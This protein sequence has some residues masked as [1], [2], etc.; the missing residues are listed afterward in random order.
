[1]TALPSITVIVPAHNDVGC[2]AETVRSCW[3][4]TYAPARVIVVAD[5]CTD[6]TAVVAERAGA[7]VILGSGG[8]KAGAQNLALP[9]VDTEVVVALDSNVTMAP[10]S[11]EAFAA[12]IADGYA[13]VCSV[14]Y[15]S[16]ERTIFE[17]ARFVTRSIQNHW[18]NPLQQ[19]LG[20][21]SVLPGPLVAYDVGALRAVGGFSTD[22]LTEDFD[23]TWTFHAHGYPV[24]YSPKALA[25]KQEPTNV[26]TYVDQIKRWTAGYCQC[27]IKHRA[28]LLHSRGGLIIGLAFLDYYLLWT[29]NLNAIV[30]VATGRFTLNLWGWWWLVMQALLAVSIVRS[31]PIRKAV[32]YWPAAQL[33]MMIEAPV[34]LWVNIRELV[35]GKHQTSWTGRQRRRTV[36]GR[37]PRGR[38]T[39]F[40]CGSAA[41]AAGALTGFVV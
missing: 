18:S 11:L 33:V 3:A 30:S 34:N 14:V 2:I 37:M 27:L 19:S 7:E 13:A 5:S 21:L 9:A 32:A 40:A 6:D 26:R 29:F 24:T 20:W 39:I 36:V 23:L 1:V 17:K 10:A 4:Q 8:S 22:T 16:N 15:P 38:R 35:L 31:V 41:A 25:F 28:Y 12:L